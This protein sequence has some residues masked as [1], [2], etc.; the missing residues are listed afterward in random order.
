MANSCDVVQVISKCI[1]NSETNK[2]LSLFEDPE[3]AET[4]TS[5]CWDILHVLCAKLDNETYTSQPAIFQCC[6]KLVNKVA[7]ISRPEEALLELIEQAESSD[8]DTGFLALLKA[9]HNLLIR[10]PKKRGHSLVW[11]LDLVARY[12]SA[13]PEPSSHGLEGK[14]RVLLDLDPSVR[15]IVSIYDAIVPFYESF[16]E[17]VSLARPQESA[18][19][20]VIAQRQYQ[21]YAL[22]AFLIHLLGK[23]LIF[24]DLEFDGKTKSNSRCAAEKIVGFINQLVADILPILFERCINTKRNSENNDLDTDPTIMFLSEEKVPIL[25]LA[26]LLYLVLAGGVPRQCVPFVYS[27]HFMF[28]VGLH[29]STELLQVSH[30]MCVWKGLQLADTLVSILPQ[31]SISYTMLDIPIHSKFCTTL[32]SVVVFCSEEGCRKKG[33]TILQNYV[34]LMDL[35]ARY[36]VFIK[37]FP[38]LQHSGVKGVLVTMLKDTIRITM[39]DVHNHAVRL[40]R[41]ISLLK[42]VEVYCIVPNGPEVDLMDHSDHIISLLNLLWFLALA[43]TGDFLGLWEH[44]PYLDRNFINPLTDALK[45]SRAHY[46]LK[47]HQLEEERMTQSQEK[48]DKSEK[49]VS[50]TVQGMPVPDLSYDEKKQILNVALNKFSIMECL[51]NNIREK[52][53]SRFAARHTGD[54]KE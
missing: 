4:I 21:R 24:M 27:P 53:E 47:I 33:I 41:G 35:P 54:P 3:N 16:I 48:K 26:N 12:M 42:L 52:V 51:L 45:L 9:I 11:C 36:Q 6:E 28:P 25:G 49:E 7:E 23:P 18:D 29:L 39:A 34:K 38:L 46:E 32:E 43:D 5:N 17:E 13:L 20:A 31:S 10:L 1:E 44:A 15:R 22:A 2:L 37:L 50:V 8:N 19:K 40:Y 30:D 14:E